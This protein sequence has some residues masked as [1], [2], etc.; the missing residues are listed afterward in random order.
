MERKRPPLL[1]KH[2]SAEEETLVEGVKGLG[3]VLAA[4]VDLLEACGRQH[5]RLL[6]PLKL[7][8]RG[9]D[10]GL[11]GEVVARVLSGRPTGLPVDLGLEGR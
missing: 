1:V 6:V 3:L 5:P 4:R 11:E 9:A 10:Q 8:A 2:L 7:E